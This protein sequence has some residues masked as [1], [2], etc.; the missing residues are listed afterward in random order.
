LYKSQLFACVFKIEP[1]SLSVRIQ[2]TTT[3][4]LAQCKKQVSSL[5]YTFKNKAL[6]WIFQVLFAYSTQQRFR[7]TASYALL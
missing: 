2:K 6:Y 7:E 4:T 1:S 3:F 5:Q